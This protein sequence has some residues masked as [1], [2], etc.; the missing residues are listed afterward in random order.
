MSLSWRCLPFEKRDKALRL[1]RLVVDCEEVLGLYRA[2]VNVA[3]YRI[4]P[5]PRAR[6]VVALLL[7]NRPDD[8]L[9]LALSF[10]QP[11]GSM[12]TV[13]HAAGRIDHF[14]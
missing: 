10:A 9:G 5:S 2:R 8:T 7:L 1:A 13:T 3:K 4:E 12:I 6:P 14:W 11:H